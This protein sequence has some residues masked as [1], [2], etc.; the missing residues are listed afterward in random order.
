VDV[1]WTVKLSSFHY[2]QHGTGR[3]I[4][5]DI[6]RLIGLSYEWLA[7]HR[8]KT[9]SQRSGSVLKASQLRKGHVVKINGLAYQV[10]QIDI[11]TPSARGANT[12]YRV[13][14]TGITSGQNIDQTYKGNDSLEE[15]NLDR[16]PVSFLYS[17]PETYHFMDAENFE[18]YSLHAEQL[19]E[20][21][22][23]IVDNMT[24]ITA[25]LLDS[26]VVAIELPAAVELEIVETAPVIKGATATNRN[27]PATLSNS[28]VVQVPD[29]LTTGDRVRINTE[30]GKFMS[31]A[32]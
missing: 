30:T 27:K 21:S 8:L 4:A 32:R 18:Q 20:Q 7:Y 28:R 23:W 6:D 2:G 15:M 17:E 26:Q 1:R 19:G 31:R 11:Q 25:L 29:H 9:I 14:L 3:A 12:L 10:Q 24:G 13:R 16:R 5:L 22:D